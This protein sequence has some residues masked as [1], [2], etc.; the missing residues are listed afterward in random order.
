MLGKKVSKASSSLWNRAKLFKEGM[1][2]LKGVDA[3]LVGWPAWRAIY[4]VKLLSKL[5]GKPLIVDA[6]ISLYDTEV[7]DRKRVLLRRYAYT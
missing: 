6:F 5:L 3:I 2:A 1:S 7:F 4:P